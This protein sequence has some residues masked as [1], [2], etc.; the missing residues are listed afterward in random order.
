MKETNNTNNASCYN[1]HFYINSQY[2]NLHKKM[3]LTTQSC[4][5]HQYVD[6]DEAEF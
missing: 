4:S 5:Q 2:C 3:T 6:E 1:C